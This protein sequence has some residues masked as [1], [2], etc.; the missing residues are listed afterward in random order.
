VS[1]PRVSKDSSKRYTIY[2]D[3][4]IEAGNLK[5][6]DKVCR[7]RE[8]PAFGDSTL[9]DARLVGMLIGDGSYGYNNTPKY[10]SEDKELLSYIK[11]KYKTGLNASH[12]TKKG[13]RYEEIRINNI[14]AFLREIGIYGQTK[15]GKRLP[16]NYQTLNKENTILL[17]SGLYDTDGCIHVGSKINNDYIAL[18]QSNKEILKQVQLLW[19]KFGVTSSIVLCKPNISEN[20]KDKKPWYNLLIK[21]GENLVRVSKTLQLLVGNKKQKL[22]LISSRNSRDLLI[23]K[24][25][26]NTDYLFDKVVNIKPIGEQTIYNLSAG[27]SHTYLANDIITHNTAGDNDSDFG[28]AQELVYNP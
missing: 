28:S 24:K 12:I 20:R 8:I 6:G 19:K 10:S 18:T 14:C 16:I 11:N 23:K 17:L 1:H 22:F 4:F 7:C 25:H 3:K 5:V 2:S 27:L 13:L 9:F 21:G 15:C 26:Y